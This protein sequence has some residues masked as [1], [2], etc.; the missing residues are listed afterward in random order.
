MAVVVC[1][2]VYSELEY[3]GNPNPGNRNDARAGGSLVAARAFAGL[4]LL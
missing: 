2:I 1:D 3:D 4:L